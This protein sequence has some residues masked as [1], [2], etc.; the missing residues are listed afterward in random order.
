MKRYNCTL[1]DKRGEFG[2]CMEAHS[3]GRYV[4]FSDVEKLQR[5]EHE[6]LEKFHRTGVAIERAISTGSVLADH[7]LK[8]RLEML[9]NHH[10]REMELVAQLADATRQCGV[11]AELLRETV[12]VIPAI[13]V[14]IDDLPVVDAFL[15]RIEAALAGKTPD[16]W[17]P[18]DTALRDGR[19]VLVYRPL[20]ENS[21]DERIAVKR[22][23][24]GRGHSCWDKTVPPGQTPCN[25]TDG[26]CHVTHWMPLPDEPAQQGGEPC[27]TASRSSSKA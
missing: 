22:I 20:A 15:E 7:P 2:D 25:P 9:A 1:S 18:I 27:A 12:R 14:A 17:L 13:G 8:S 16:A 11:M 3:A 21:G 6:L 10:M 19:K 26:A 4:L 23:T 24:G 5:R